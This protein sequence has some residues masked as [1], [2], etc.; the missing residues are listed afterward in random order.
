MSFRAP[1][2]PNDAMRAGSGCIRGY[3]GAVQFGAT[4][5]RPAVAPIWSQAHASAAGAHPTAPVARALPSR[6]AEQRLGGR[7]DLFKKK[8]IGNR[9]VLKHKTMCSTRF[10]PLKSL[11]SDLFSARRLFDFSH[12]SHCGK[13]IIHRGGSGICAHGRVKSHCKECGGG[14]ADRS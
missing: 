2:S 4:H 9:R 10:P 13:C 11:W 6:R 14:V 8:R 3:S 12:L 1:L 7:G 5:K